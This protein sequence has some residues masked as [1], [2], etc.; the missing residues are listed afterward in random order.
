MTYNKTSSDVIN[1]MDT[2]KTT[3]Q[4]ENKESIITLSFI[5]GKESEEITTLMILLIHGLVV[6]F[7]TS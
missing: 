6:H 7:M 2:K 1:L 5:R 3:H 4:R